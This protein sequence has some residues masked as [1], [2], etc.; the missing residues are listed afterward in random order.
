M[1]GVESRFPNLEND[2][3]V[4]SV[5]PYYSIHSNKASATG[6][7]GLVE[8]AFF[9]CC[10]FAS[11]RGTKQSRYEVSYGNGVSGICYPAAVSGV[12]SRKRAFAAAVQ[13]HNLSIPEGN[14]VLNLK[15]LNSPYCLTK[16]NQK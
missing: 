11:L 5:T 3:R 9:V 13:H 15:S 12:A 8:G 7:L 2:L 6:P 16:P 14:L 4:V 10:R 1:G